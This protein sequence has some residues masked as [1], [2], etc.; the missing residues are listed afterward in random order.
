M[1]KVSKIM[2]TIIASLMAIALISANVYAT[3]ME[4]PPETTTAP[5]T[6]DVASPTADPNAVTNTELDPNAVADPNAVVDP[7]ATT[8]P[9][10]VVPADQNETIPYE[11]AN[12][13]P[14]QPTNEVSLNTEKKSDT[15]LSNFYI[16]AAAIGGFVFIN[17]ILS[18]LIFIR[19]GR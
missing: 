10:D 17:F 13:V 3:N 2:L 19:T 6:G 18:I 8:V 5:T 15:D 4:V 14:A 12:A 7:N 1:N 16:I 11:P 9:G